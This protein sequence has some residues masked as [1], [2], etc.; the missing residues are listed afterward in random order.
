[1]KQLAHDLDGQAQHANQQADHEGNWFYRNDRTFQRSVANFARR[2]SNFH[3]RMENY[4]AEPWQLDG[5]LRGLVRDARAVQSRVQRSRNVDDHTAAD[6]SKTVGVLNEMIR[7]YQSD[8]NGS[9]SYPGE[10]RQPG[11][12]GYDNRHEARGSA[13]GAYNSQQVGTL[14]HELAERSTRLGNLINQLSGRYSGNG[15]QNQSFQAI[16]HFA[17]QANAF[18]ERYEGGLTPEDVRGNVGHLWDD[19]RQADQQ[20]R[21]AN[22]PELQGEWSGMMQLLARIRSAAGF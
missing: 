2:A 20:F 13:R 8:S 7:L 15:G 16:Q 11:T 1:M 14:V 10:Y 19:A 6:W 9:A 17:E 21:Q 12:G 3:E 5:E 18:H 4:R 22:V